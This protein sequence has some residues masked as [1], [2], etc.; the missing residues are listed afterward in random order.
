MTPQELE[1]CIEHNFDIIW[2]LYNTS[3][4]IGYYYEWDCGYWELVCKEIEQLEKITNRKRKD[5]WSQL[6][7]II[8]DDEYFSREADDED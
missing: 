2:D 3:V 4:A 8:D 1:N 7:W 5:L 6:H